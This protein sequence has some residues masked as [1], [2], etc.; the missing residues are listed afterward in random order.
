MFVNEQILCIVCLQRYRY[1]YTQT[2]THSPSP[3]RSSPV[4]L[5]VVQV[6]PEDP[7]SRHVHVQGHHVLQAGDERDVLSTV[8]SHLPHLVAVGEQQVG[9]S[10]WKTYN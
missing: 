9:D 8:H 1:I 4:D 3:S 6:R 5:P 10:T 7:V 2:H